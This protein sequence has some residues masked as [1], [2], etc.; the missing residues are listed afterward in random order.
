MTK[1]IDKLINRLETT[2]SHLCVG[3]DSNYQN[4][5][6]FFKK[7]FA[8]DIEK[9]ILNFNQNIIEST[10]DLAIIY[11][12]NLSFYAGFGE[13]G[14]RALAA[15]NDY[16]K[17]RHP[18][19]M[20]LAD[21]KRSEMGQSVVMVAQEIFDW[22]KFD[23]VMVTPWFGFDTLKDYFQDESKGALVYIHDSNPSA[24]EIQDLTLADGRAVYEV[25]AQK[26]AHEWNLNGNLWAE[27][28]I[29][30]LT[31]L[32]RTREILGPEMP[33]LVAGIGAQG[34]KASDLKGLFGKNNRRLIAN[35]SRG[36]IFSSPA[37]TQEI[38]FQDVREAAKKL[39]DE[40][41][42][43]SLL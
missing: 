22:L 42:T 37:T 24:A 38:Y 27:A 5:P 8:G 33:L 3:L 7:S 26:V 21:C 9:T 29:T 1:F 16:L 35:S 12:M 31:Q 15:T 34:G 41:W 19:I 11:K 25:V 28:G 36:I 43:T 23:C 40:L 30:Y 13:A 4:I 18:E 2:D 17:K 32:R 20:I 6:D 39:R 14:L 10:A